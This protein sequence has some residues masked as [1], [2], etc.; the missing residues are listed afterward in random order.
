[1]NRWL[2]PE[3]PPRTGEIDFREQIRDASG[4]RVP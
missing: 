2:H 3:L 4:P 1:M